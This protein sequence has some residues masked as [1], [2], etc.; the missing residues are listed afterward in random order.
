MSSTESHVHFGWTSVELV[1]REGLLICLAWLSVPF[2]PAWLQ[3]S[4]VILAWAITL[5]AVVSASWLSLI[6]I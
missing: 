1:W 3:A 4:G 5:G 2:L 6:H